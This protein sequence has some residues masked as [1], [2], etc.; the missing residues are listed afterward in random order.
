[1]SYFYF[2]TSVHSNPADMLSRSDDDPPDLSAT[3]DK[4][5]AAIREFVG[6]T[7]H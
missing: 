2:C 1:M 6:N 7:E 4:V 3:K 5:E